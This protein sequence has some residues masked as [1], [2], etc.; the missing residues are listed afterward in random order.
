MKKNKL[1]DK[2]IKIINNIKKMFKK[3]NILNLINKLK[4][5]LNKEEDIKQKNLNIKISQKQKINFFESLFNL[6]NSW[7]PITNSLSIML[8]QTKDKNVKTLLSTILKNLNKWKKLQENFELFPKIFSQFDIYITK[9]WEVSWKLA[10]SLEIILN[11]EEKNKDLKQKILWAL[12]YPIIIICLSI[13]MIV[14]FMV[15]VIPKVQDMYKDARV[16]LPDLTQK[17]IDISNFLK[18]NWII[19]L[20]ILALIIFWINS[21]RYNKNT[22]YYFDKTILEIPI[23]WSLIRKKIIVVFSNTL[24]VLLQNWIM[25]NQALEISK[26]SIEN[27]YYEQRLDEMLILLNEWIPLSELMWINKLQEWIE[28]KYFPIELA[29]IVKIWEQTWKLPSLLLKISQKFNKE[30]DLIVKNLSTMIEPVVII[31]VWSI[32]GTMVMA[33][34]LPFFNMVNVV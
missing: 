26:K 4:I 34:L 33:I 3:D 23:F 28:D 18:E 15:F 9:M 12:I 13:C 7:I 24:W 16:N 8:Y 6:I 32:V 2:I 14:G 1:N 31:L 11:K 30:I 25:I 22:K 27:E 29:S 17:V 5:A 21:L 10:N 20:I 19:I